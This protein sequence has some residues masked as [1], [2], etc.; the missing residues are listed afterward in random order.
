MQAV[1]GL[2]TVHTMQSLTEYHS[3]QDQG[4]AG[5]IQGLLGAS[6]VHAVL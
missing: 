3:K 4:Q 5:V 2:I 6:T 1:G